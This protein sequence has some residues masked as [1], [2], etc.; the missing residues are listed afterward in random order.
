M[1]VKDEMSK[2][3]VIEKNENNLP[4]PQ[5]YGL[6]QAFKFFVL[7][8]LLMVGTARAATYYVDPGAGSDT[9]GGSSSSPWRTINKAKTVVNPGDT[10]NLLPGSYGT[11]TFTP[12][13]RSGTS[14]SYITY[15]NAPGSPPHAA[16][17]SHILFRGDHDF[18]TTISGVDVQN[19]SEAAC[20]KIG[21]TEPGYSNSGHIKIIDCKAH[22][23]S[24][25]NGP[26]IGLIYIFYGNNVLI[27]GCEAYDNSSF[28][29]GIIMYS[30]SNITVRGCHVHDIT[31]SGIRTGGGAN[32]TI[33]YNIIHTQRPELPGDQHGS[34]IAIRASDT[35]IRGN[36]I[37][38]FGNTRPIRFYQQVAGPSGYRNMLVE[39][40][41]V[42]KTPDYT[43]D[44]WWTELIDVGDNVVVR[45]NT[46]VGGLMIC[47]AQNAN[48]SGLSIYNNVV[49]GDLTLDGPYVN[50]DGTPGHDRWV[51]VREGGN[52]FG[53]L[54][55]HGC[56]WY[57]YYSEFS[58]TS[59][60]IVGGGFSVGSFFASGSAHYPYTS[61][62]PYLL[63]Q[64][65]RAINFANSAN[66]PATDLL[67]N[68]RGTQ[69]DTGCYEFGG[70][71]PEPPTNSPPV[72]APIGNKSVDY[73]QTLTFTV[74]ATD[75]DNDSLTYT[76]AILPQGAN[77][78]SGS[79]VFTWTPSP[80]QAGF[81]D[82]TFTVDDLKGG[83]DS[84]TITINSI[85]DTT[86]P[87]AASVT[88]MWNSVEI[89]FTKALDQASAQD[90]SNYAI[91]NSI[92]INA[93]SLN[94]DSTKVV[95]QTSGH[96]ENTIYSLTVSGVKDLIGNLI[97]P[98]TLQYTYKDGLVGLW[99]FDEG[100]GTT[101]QDSAD[102]DNTGALINGTAWTGQT[103]LS[104]DG[105]DDALEVPTIGFNANTG[106]VS[107]WAYPKNFSTANNY[108]FGH[109]IQPWSNVI[110]LYI[111][112][113]SLTL[114]IGDSHYKQMNIQALT[115]NKWYHFALTWNGTNYVVYVD[116]VTKATGSYTGLNALE[117]YADI[118]NN[119]N[120]AERTNE[121]FDGL[122]DDV[123]VYNRALTAA[124][125]LGIFND[126]KLLFDSI[127]D[128]T[129][130]ENEL[131]N[132]TVNMQAPDITILAEPLPLGA[133]FQNTSFTWT[134]TYDQAGSYDVNF[135]ATDGEI[136]DIELIT[137]TV[138]N[139]NRY[140]VI[141]P[142]AD[143]SVDEDTLLTF[144]V[145]VDD[146]DGDSV[147]C[148]AQNLP[149]GSNF[150][151]NV[152]TWTPTDTQDGTYVISFVATDGELEDVESLIITVN[153]VT[154]PVPD[155]TVVII[156]NGDPA[157]SHTG[158]WLT[159][160][161]SNPYGTESLWSRD[162]DTYTWTFTPTVSGNY[163]IS[164]WWTEY[165]SRGSRIPVRIQRAGRTRIV[166]INQ[167]QNGGQ[168][169]PLRQYY[170]YAGQS[171]NITIT[172][173]SGS[174]STC[175]DAVKFT[176]T[177]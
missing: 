162:G 31:E 51:N 43:Q 70:S 177:D 105:Y 71:V 52:L 61:G 142:I 75:P 11:L 81:H 4:T 118:G 1:K 86:P 32:Y 145:Y 95:L 36:I 116:G 66:A 129:V 87:Q 89:V 22:G 12:S 63:A 56:G 115:A 176:K 96:S 37:Y 42:Y 161:G 102:G 122:I 170:Y 128:K 93:A 16:K 58:P 30:S 18:Y 113:A 104:F 166:Y 8:L 107:I 124:E 62:Y 172:S 140:P 69:P 141:Q 97:V 47:F 121:A 7:C 25:G 147:S 65:S 171:Y 135:I 59:T 27:E 38:N 98:V 101:A 154:P 67:G 57:C 53:S 131:L 112:D 68:S 78:N 175:A 137:I 84:E 126:E 3:R 143:K 21:G 41:L 45:N 24:I 6:C 17:F 55:S 13:D 163:E 139:V 134:P 108:L 88:A 173:L 138:N 165:P 9:A 83:T 15:Q 130:N 76:A 74:T 149:A 54:Q 133:D 48:G 91:N 167:Q 174:A 85:A 26:A 119:G 155:E 103:Q 10:V 20:I 44:M 29:D 82:I 35:V 2:L 109:T 64:S 110:Q 77:F 106:T 123:S 114:G 136:E 151:S 28:G 111:R 156:D 158:T 94:A 5:K 60:S 80:T 99:Q 92:T 160:G 144:S 72:L 79:G 146:P 164:M 49:T 153:D 14:Q 90:I 152:F 168:W 100:S 127:G 33:E 73:G 169:N 50:G 159:S 40:N 150:A 148:I 23:Y 46:F 132:F 157:T 125:V 34:G 19:S 39:N 117:A 120:R